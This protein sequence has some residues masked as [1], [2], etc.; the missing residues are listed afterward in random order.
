MNLDNGKAKIKH[1]GRDINIVIPSKK[2]WFFLVFGTLWLIVWFSFSSSLGFLLRPSP[3]GEIGMSVFILFWMLLWLLGGLAILTLLLWG[4]FG[5]EQI[6]LTGP[7]FM[8]SKTV[9]GL[10]VKNNLKSH[11]VKNF[12]FNSTSNISFGSNYLAPYGL[13]PGKIKFDYGLKTYSFGMAVDEA[14]AHYLIEILN[15]QLLE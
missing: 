13:G 11:E 5:K 15:N 8:L 9:I 14:E 3:D 4:Y 6:E 2:N 12:R 10:G 7:N 1:T